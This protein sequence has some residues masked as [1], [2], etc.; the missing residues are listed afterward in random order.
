[1]SQNLKKSFTYPFAFFVKATIVVVAICLCCFRLRS[2]YA[3]N[4][5]AYSLVIMK[6]SHKGTFFKA[7]VPGLFMIVLIFSRCPKKCILA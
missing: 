7:K 6:C 4:R 1:M 2:F 3:T 5:E